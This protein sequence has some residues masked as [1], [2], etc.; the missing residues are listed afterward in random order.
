MYEVK[1]NLGRLQNV[2]GVLE[3][4]ED[5]KAY[6]LHALGGGAGRGR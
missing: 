1:V 4:W 5:E 3:R 6:A 2:I